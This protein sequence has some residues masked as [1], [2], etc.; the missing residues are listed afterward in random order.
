MDK[1]INKINVILLVAGCGSRI[2]KYSKN[3]KCLLKIGQKSILE[4]NFDIWKSLGLKKI[5][6][7]VGYKKKLLENKL[8]KYKKNFKIK[9]ILN[10]K[11]VTHGNCYSLYLAL[12]KVKGEAIFFDGDL[13]YNYKILKHFLN[14]KKK[15][16]ILAGPGNINDI[17]CA[18]VLVNK[19]IVKRI[20]EKK[21]ILNKEKKKYIFMG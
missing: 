6:I 5:F 2:S 4:R 10:N 7:V 20:I 8:I 17:E 18:K 16:S 1:K 12:K 9:K 13:I 11:F 21:K 19:K 14:H 3:P 15:D